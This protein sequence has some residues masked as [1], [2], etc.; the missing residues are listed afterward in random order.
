MARVATNEET[1]L[2]LIPVG[3]WEAVTATCGF[4]SFLIGSV[5]IKFGG[6]PWM[7]ETKSNET[8]GFEHPH[9]NASHDKQLRGYFSSHTTNSADCVT[10]MNNQLTPLI[11][12]P[13]GLMPYSQELP[14]NSY[15]LKSIPIPS[16]LSFSFRILSTFAFLSL[17]YSFTC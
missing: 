8:G 1:P 17:S 15:T 3:G 2:A 9:A 7:A 13:E 11:M 12:N 14:N 4:V 10:V 16:I 5:V 6:F